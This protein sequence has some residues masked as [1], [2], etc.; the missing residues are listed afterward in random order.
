MNRG[1]ILFI[2]LCLA[3]VLSAQAKV[4]AVVSSVKGNA[5]YMH[6]GKTLLL[7]AGVHL[8]SQSEIFTEIGAQVTLNDYYDHVFHLSGSGHITIHQNLVELK[9]GYLWAQVKSYDANYGPMRIVTANSSV[10]FTEGE[11]VISFDNITSKTQLL[12]VKGSFLLKN[13]LQEFIETDV[14][15]GKF[16]FIATN[17]NDGRPRTPTAVGYKSYKKITGLF[18]GVVPLGD[19][20]NIAHKSN[21]KP[22]EPYRARSIA[23]TQTVSAF[24]EALTGQKE[25]AHSGKVLFV[26][27]RSKERAASDKLKREK[28]LS[29]YS[30]SSLSKPIFVKKKKV[31]KWKASYA[32][33]SEVKVRIFGQ[34]NS[35][36]RGI[37]SISK[38]IVKKSKRSAV[39][40]KAIK[41]VSPVKTRM[42]ASVSDTVSKSAFE[43]KL[44]SEYKNQM[45][46]KSELNGLIDELKSVDSD[47]QKN[48]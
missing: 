7:R 13:T 31:K 19:L 2:C 32:G 47:Y 4:V 20:K 34:G 36:S 5:F 28:L 18:T 43:G 37:A 35:T 26:K 25:S 16:S 24:E 11:G 8:P 22:K 46:H 38:P 21:M 30:K 33:K 12:T 45:R 10:E 41:K 27:T 9:A 17:F 6:A 44:T 42:P 29:A 3:P 40:V 1:L 15:E 48:Y 39:L 14:E 23:S